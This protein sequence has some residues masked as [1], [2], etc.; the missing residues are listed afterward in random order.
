MIWILKEYL[1]L[2]NCD[3]KKTSGRTQKFKYE[4]TI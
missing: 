1:I 4:C 2:Y 3:K